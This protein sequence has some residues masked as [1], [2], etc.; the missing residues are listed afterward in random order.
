M[1]A[2]ATSLS[3]SVCNFQ[4][5][6]PGPWLLARGRHAVSPFGGVV[7]LPELV[8]LAVLL[9]LSA[10]FSGSETALFSLSQARLAELT[11]GERG[12]RGRLVARLLAHP[13][14]LLVIVLFGN[15]VV[16]VFFFALSAMVSFRLERAGAPAAAVGVGLG[17]LLAVVV[18]GE[19]TPKSVAVVV[20]E[21]VALW[22]GPVLVAVAWVL[23]PVVGVFLRVSDAVARLLVRES[24]PPYIT[25]EE[26]KMLVG[27]S[28]E[29]GLIGA[30][31]QSLMTRVVELGEVSVREVM[32]P[33]VDMPLFALGRPR[34]ELLALI[35]RTRREFVPVFRE[36]IDSVEGVVRS[37]RVLLEPERALEGMVEPVPLVPESRTVEQ[38][39]TEFRA[40]GTKVAVVVDEYGGTS[41]LVELDDLVEAVVGEM[42]DGLEPADRPVM[43][44]ELGPRSF[45]LDARLG[46][47]EWEDLF[48]V[49]LVER[50]GL[51]AARPVTVGG[52]VTALL[53]HWPTVD[54]RVDYRN[55]RFTVVQMQG[56]RLS[57]I[58]VDLLAK[59][60][61]EKAG[62]RTPGGGI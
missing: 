19:V 13:H 60:G 43:V 37:T 6:A 33:R 50:E 16:N 53:G 44:E 47:R 11:R 39:L 10:F 45:L 14:H 62:N 40:R 32:L 55:L 24:A 38:L 21:P 29:Q 12:R 8:A 23:R 59:A 31:E 48:E 34:E 9:A 3:S 1:A 54:D 7:S 28:E 35:R 20:A 57:K 61:G 25:A 58:R 42:P 51:G 52:F 26:L 49:D 30:G 46:I 4:P 17:A 22:A 36:S 41:G 56:R 5:P 27:L 18:F 2:R 15:L